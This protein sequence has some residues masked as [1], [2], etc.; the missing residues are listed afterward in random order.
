MTGMVHE[1]SFSLPDTL[2]DSQFGHSNDPSKS[3]FM[4]HHKDK[5]IDGT[6]FQYL[7]ANVGSQTRI[8][9]QLLISV[10]SPMCPRSVTLISNLQIIIQASNSILVYTAL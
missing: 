6:L 8:E 3:A 4:Y 2:R 1:A 9:D 7:A 5:C 10:L